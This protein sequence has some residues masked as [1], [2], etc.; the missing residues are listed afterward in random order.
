[1][2][3]Q[4]PKAYEDL[5]G[6]DMQMILKGLKAR[7]NVRSTLKDIPARVQ[8]MTLTESQI[9]HD[10]G[11]FEPVEVPAIFPQARRGR[12]W[13]AGCYCSFWMRP[14]PESRVRI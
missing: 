7:S 12:N 8:A 5:L 9:L 6:T 10:Q 1:M 2:Q 3:L 14:I 4:K 11:Q 13:C